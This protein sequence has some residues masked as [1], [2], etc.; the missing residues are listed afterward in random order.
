MLPAA[1][2]HFIDSETEKRDGSASSPGPAACP[3]QSQEQRPVL[4][5]PAGRQA[6]ASPLRYSLM[7][8]VT[9]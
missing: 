1:C 5:P 9:H 6:A 7:L 4:Q 8:A 2:P 3:L